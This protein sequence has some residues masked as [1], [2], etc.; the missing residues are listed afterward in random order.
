A[1]RMVLIAPRR[2][3]LWMDLARLNEASGALGAAQRA[4][5]ACLSLVPGGQ[6]LHNEAALGLHALKR[7]LN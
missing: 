3:E 5:E 7:R 1:K 4:Y 2:P 6:A